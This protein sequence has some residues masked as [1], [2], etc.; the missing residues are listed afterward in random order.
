MST[1]LTKAEEKTQ[2]NIKYLQWKIHKV[3]LNGRYFRV[4]PTGLIPPVVPSAACFLWL[5][6][7]SQKWTFLTLKSWG[8]ARRDAELCLG[9]P[10]NAWREGTGLC[11]ALNCL[12]CN[13]VINE[14]YIKPGSSSQRSGIYHYHQKSLELMLSEHS[15]CAMQST[16]DFMYPDS[17]N[18][19]NYPEVKVQLTLFYRWGNRIRE[20]KFW[21]QLANGRVGIRSQCHLTPKSHAIN[22]H[23]LCQKELR[24][25]E[26]VGG[27]AGE[28]SRALVM[29]GQT[30]QPRGWMILCDLVTLSPAVF[31][32]AILV[33]RHTSRWGMRVAGHIK[34]GGTLCELFRRKNSWVYEATLS[35]PSSGPSSL[36]YWQLCWGNIWE[37]NSGRTGTLWTVFTAVSWYSEQH[38]AC[39]GASYTFAEYLLLTGPL[40]PLL[41]LLICLPFCQTFSH[42]IL[43][44]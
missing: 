8:Y 30:W 29:G 32:W 10:G 27:G 38:L 9:F 19:H 6:H 15:P 13:S 41:T 14:N 21:A 16:K 4:I 17:F 40:R 28:R 33:W 25:L 37:V 23:A 42:A 26:L 20:V 18:P 2:F 44:A 1:P 35:F 39:C 3:F 36:N 34:F 7:C 22:H 12:S 24:N 31:L 11:I 43:F 5:L